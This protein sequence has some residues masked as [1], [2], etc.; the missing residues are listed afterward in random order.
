MNILNI[1]KDKILNYMK[2]N[3]F[4][5]VIMPTVPT[6]ALKHNGNIKCTWLLG[7]Y[8]SVWNGLDFPAA[9]MPISSIFQK[10]GR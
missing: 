8:C 9:T 5:M 4:D 3:M 1:E 6:P 2:K 7:S 10:E